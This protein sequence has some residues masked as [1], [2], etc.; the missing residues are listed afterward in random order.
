MKTIFPM[1]GTLRNI[2]GRGQPIMKTIC[3]PFTRAFFLGALSL[4]LFSFQIADAFPPAP[5]HTIYGLI[6]DE[7][8]NPLADTKAKVYLET[9]SGVVI[10]TTI[11]PGLDP[12]IN[13]RLTVPM[14]SGI[15][16]DAY[17][18][19]ALKPT[20][21]FK[22]KVKIGNV[23]YLPL[24]MTANYANLGQPAQSTR[25]DLTLGED[26]DGD[27][28][29][30]AW[31]RMLLDMMGGGTLADIRPEDDFDHDGL[32][33]YA[34]YIAGTYAFDPTDGFTLNIV[35][36]TNGAP[37]LEFLAIRSR[38]YTVYGST[39]MKTWT[40]V[41]FKIPAEGGTPVTRNNYIAT[42][43]RTL[44]IEAVLPPVSPPTFFK[45]KVQ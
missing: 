19:T 20:V 21:P 35:R 8:G 42:D 18:P 14:D 1:P 36:G 13:Y 27:G 45:V 16:A 37:L 26:S 3:F 11:V 9:S 2:C 17:K 28:L 12:G 25:L 15:T 24:E 6:R 4:G 44:Q 22:I 40:P 7:Y 10:E 32:S 5:P 41:L 23:T 30:D 29:P 33:N 38:T 39:D 34:E 43:V 31:E